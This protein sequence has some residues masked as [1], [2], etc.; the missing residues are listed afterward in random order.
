M[1]QRGDFG[2]L[3]ID[4]NVIGGF[5]SWE[6][7]VELRKR[8]QHKD[9]IY[10]LAKRKIVVNDWWINDWVDECDMDLYSAYGDRP[11]I[12]GRYKV[13]VRLSPSDDIGKRVTTKQLEMEVT[14]ER[15]SRKRD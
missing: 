6:L 4:G 13:R 3:S 12:M 5:H 9:P 14:G 15:Y 8:V 7:T 2:K 11:V 1:K 10:R